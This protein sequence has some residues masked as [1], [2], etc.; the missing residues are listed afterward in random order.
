MTNSDPKSR[1]NQPTELTDDELADAKGAG[2]AEASFGRDLSSVRVHTGN[3]ASSSAESS[4]SRAYTGGGKVTN[5]GKPAS[6]SSSTVAHELKHTIN[7]GNGGSNE[8]GS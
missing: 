6:S 1:D 3:S 2:G 8:G 4:G 7:Q 5:S